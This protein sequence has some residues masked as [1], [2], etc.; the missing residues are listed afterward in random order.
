MEA[1]L[2]LRPTGGRTVRA[3]L[4]LSSDWVAEGKGN[5]RG[6]EVRL[7][8]SYDSG[9][10]G[11]MTLTGLW[12]PGLFRLT[13]EVQAADCTGQADGTFSFSPSR[14]IRWHRQELQRGVDVY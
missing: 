4:Q 13:G 11:I 10:P 7:E 3:I 9:C 8:L 14:P 12:D 1:G 6:E 5:R 2:E